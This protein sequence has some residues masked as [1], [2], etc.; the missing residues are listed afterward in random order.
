MTIF[1]NLIN[2]VYYI[3]LIGLLYQIFIKL[4]SQKHFRV[5]FFLVLIAYIAAEYFSY[6]GNI[7]LSDAF[8]AV[9]HCVICMFFG[10]IFGGKA[11]RIAVGAIG[12]ACI[13]AFSGYYW[14]EHLRGLDNVNIISLCVIGFC[15][16]NALSFILN[17]TKS[18]M[19][20]MSIFLTS[21]IWIGGTM[22]LS[23]S[24]NRN[25]VVEYDFYRFIPKLILIFLFTRL[26]YTYKTN[27]SDTGL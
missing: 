2:I 24:L 9:G 16:S 1:I 15:A 27:K 14:P 21:G 17:K 7:R 26:I 19:L 20:Y 13:V 12:F 11:A 25:L 3:T 8:Y 18:R 10:T 4:K 6:I 5:H 23:L 22:I